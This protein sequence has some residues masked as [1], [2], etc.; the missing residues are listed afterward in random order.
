[1]SDLAQFVQWP[2][3]H[4]IHMQQCTDVQWSWKTLTFYNVCPMNMKQ[5]PEVPTITCPESPSQSLLCTALCGMLMTIETKSEWMC[6]ETEQWQGYN[7][8]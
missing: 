6:E 2:P 5:F 1:M 3:G 4:A 7:I 8:L